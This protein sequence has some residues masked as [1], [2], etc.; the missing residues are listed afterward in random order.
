[1]TAEI[2]PARVG[3][4]ESRSFCCGVAEK[5][6]TVADTEFALRQVVADFGLDRQRAREE[7]STRPGPVHQK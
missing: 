7:G 2:H 3:T 1:M 4:A 6:S 5:L